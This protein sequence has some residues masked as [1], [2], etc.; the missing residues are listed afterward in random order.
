MEFIFFNRLFS[1]HAKLSD[2]LIFYFLKFLFQLIIFLLLKIRIVTLWLELFRSQILM[3]IYFRTLFHFLLCFQSFL[4]DK[5][6]ILTVIVDWRFFS[7]FLRIMVALFHIGLIIVLVFIDV[8]NLIIFYLVII[9]ILFMMSL[10]F[11]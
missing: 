11:I 5:L 10:I 8:I 7:F 9:I 3:W 6:L 4:M 1:L 2:F